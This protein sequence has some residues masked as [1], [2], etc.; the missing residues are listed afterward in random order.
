MRRRPKKIVF[1]IGVVVIVAVIGTIHPSFFVSGSGSVIGPGATSTKNDPPT[2]VLPSLS[3]NTGTDISGALSGPSGASSAKS[4]PIVGAVELIAN[5]KTGKVAFSRNANERWALASV[6]KLMTAVVATDLLDSNQH[7][8]ITESMLSVDPTERIV[9]LGDTYTVSDL[10]RVMLLPSNN[11][12]AE[13][14]AE[15]AG[16]DRFL[17]AMN[18]KAAEWGMTNTYY[19]DPSGLSAANQST[20]SDLLKLAQHIYSEYPQILA[21]TRVPQITVTEISTGRAVALNN[22]NHFAGNADFVGGKTGYTD[23]ADGNL[24]SIFSYRGDP[25]GVVVLGTDDGH[26]FDDT[27]KLFDWYKANF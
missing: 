1:F 18:A 27:M 5:L 8:T 10:L 19:D 7:I 2:L 6:S 22:I 16:R 17:A 26:R 24:L 3:A 4:A 23:Q 9:E 15:F 20:A 25:I 21:I 12:A 14:F 13:A 11:V